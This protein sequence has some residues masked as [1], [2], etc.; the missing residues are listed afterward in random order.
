MTAAEHGGLVRPPAVAGSWY[1]AAEAPLRAAVISHLA[2]VSDTDTDVTSGDIVAIIAPH[3]GLVYSGPVA[4]HAYQAVTG[5]GQRV[6]P[7]DSFRNF[8]GIDHD[9]QAI[10]EAGGSVIDARIPTFNLQV[11]EFSG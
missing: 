11:R 4:A 8:A 5:A 2:A 3:A 9:T 1:P 6:S 7:R 10:A